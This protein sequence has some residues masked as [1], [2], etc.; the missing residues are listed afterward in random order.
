MFH[1]S[2]KTLALGV[3]YPETA[4]VASDKKAADKE[5]ALFG[6]HLVFWDLNTGLTEPASFHG[7][8]DI[9]AIRF[10]E[11]SGTWVVGEGGG[12]LS[13]WRPEILPAH[14]DLPGHSPAEA[15]GLAFS[16]DSRTLYTVGDDQLLRSWDLATSAPRDSGV[17]HTSLVSCVA[18][19]ADG[20]WIATGSY[21]RNVVL[22]DAKTM[23]VRSV[24]SGHS[25]DLRAVAFSPDGTILASSGRDNQ[26][27]VWNVEDGR[28]LRSFTRGGGAVRGLGFSSEHD[29]FEANADGHLVRWRLDGSHSIVASES[30]QIHSLL[31]MAANPRFPTAILSEPTARQ[32]AEGIA[33]IASDVNVLYGC[34]GGNFRGLQ[35]GRQSCQ[36]WIDGSQP[37]ADIRTVDVAPDGLTIAVAGDDNA[38]HL[39][40]VESGQELL[41][42]ENLPAAVNQVRFS[43]DGQYLA[44]ALH[45]GTVRIWHAPLLGGENP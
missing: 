5:H 3:S 13:L 11:S 37:G 38:V 41:A 22:W 40:H 12:R 26:I 32:S 34:K 14:L 44:A 42:F 19:S 21:D 10:H 4:L 39:W 24:L 8:Q 2:E 36:R 33:G 15:W 35:I 9:H 1:P 43:P 18:T 27:R 45:N 23:T 31:V 16:D 28:L 20:R 7:L 17:S 30:E 25:G 6:D 29:L